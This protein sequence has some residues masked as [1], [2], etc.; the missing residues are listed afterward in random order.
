METFRKKYYP[1]IQFSSI[2]L[3]LFFVFFTVKHGNAS[4]NPEGIN[5]LV[6]GDWGRDGK[7]HQRDVAE[8]MGKTAEREHSRFVMTVGD[9]FYDDGVHSVTDRQWKTSFE[10][11]YTAQSLMIPWYVALGNHEYRGDPQA[12]IDYTKTSTRWNMPARYFTETIKIDDTT[13]VEFF[14]LD[15]TPLIGGYYS[16]DI[17]KAQVTTQDSARQLRWLDSALA[18]STAQWKIAVGH[19][20]VYSDSPS[21]PPITEPI[22]E[23]VNRVLPLFKKYHVQLYIC[24]HDHNMQ[25]LRSDGM[26][27]FVDGAGSQTEPTGTD[28]R[29]LFSKGK[30]SGYLSVSM[31]STQLAAQFIDYEGNT[32]YSTQ[33]AR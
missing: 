3:F 11:I 21:Y 2:L 16:Q 9:N 22:P 24:G 13:S 18:A 5:F 23:M 20:P 12:Q 17:Y 26:D 7:F 4:G 10:D 33:I 25:H 14:F 19:H 27:F 8:Q 6:I 32:L 1:P 28:S 30:T 31:T 29:T 15:T